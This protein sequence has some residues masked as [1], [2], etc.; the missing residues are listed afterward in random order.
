MLRRSCFYPSLIPNSRPY[1]SFNQAPM[2]ASLIVHCGESDHMPVC[3]N[4]FTKM[5]HTGDMNRSEDMR[6]GKR[7]MERPKPQIWYFVKT[8]HFST[9]KV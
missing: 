7:K 5:L 2:V 6:K 1:G 3:L 4:L 9:D 8:V